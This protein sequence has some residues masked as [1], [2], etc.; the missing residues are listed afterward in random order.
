MD[1]Q[2]CDGCG[3]PVVT[4]ERRGEHVCSL[5]GLVQSDSLLVRPT[6]D[7]A[8]FHRGP[9]T[10]VHTESS[11]TT[12]FYDQ[13]H[14]ANGRPISEPQRDRMRRIAFV[15]GRSRKYKERALG[16]I[17]NQ[18]RDI[19]SRL[20]MPED[21]RDRAFYIAKQAYDRHMFVGREFSLFAAACVYLSA[22]ERGITP[23]PKTLLSTINCHA[24]NPVSQLFKLYSK[25]RREFK[26]VTQT[27]TAEQ[28]LP[29]VAN[30][31]FG[32]RDISSLLAEAKLALVEIQS[33]TQHDP[34]HRKP[35]VDVA[36]ALWVVA[37]KFAPE[38]ASQPKICE[39]CHVSDVA[40]RARLYEAYP[41]LVKRRSR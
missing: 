36:A 23:I 11:L 12:T 18:V 39:L 26:V 17:Q 14:D 31:V 4:D 21:L 29:Q 19:S 38:S 5:C 32:E 3:G 10:A 9:A 22:R 40:V 6:D 1:E 30:K 41:E 8:T 20:G 2:R 16:E 33:R 7:E 25:M 37:I 35:E 13:S 24:K 27:V 28:I 34:Q 15:A